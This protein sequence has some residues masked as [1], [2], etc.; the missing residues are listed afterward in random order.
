MEWGY[1]YSEIKTR[2]KK[3]TNVQF[4]NTYLG[5]QINVSFHYNCL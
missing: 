2:I 1:I 5:M 4:I 3:L